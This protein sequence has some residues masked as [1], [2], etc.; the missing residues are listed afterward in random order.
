M[1]WS[2]ARKTYSDDVVRSKLWPSG[3]QF[4][5]GDLAIGSW[6]GIAHRAPDAQ[7]DAVVRSRPPM[8]SRVVPIMGKPISFHMSLSA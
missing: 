3:L 8:A 5:P 6:D 7:A 2:L 4:A 1:V